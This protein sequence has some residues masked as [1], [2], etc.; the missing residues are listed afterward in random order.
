MNP[1][2]MN[3]GDQGDSMC[4]A[5]RFFLRFSFHYLVGKQL[6]LLLEQSLCIEICNYFENLYFVNVGNIK[7]TI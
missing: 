7:K 5:S 3:G 1:S 6:E 2:F 4:K